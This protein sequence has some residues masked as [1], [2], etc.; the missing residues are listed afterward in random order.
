MKNII[1]I[2]GGGFARE[3]H[4]LIREI[5]LYNI[6]GFVHEKEREDMKIGKIIYPVYNEK[7]LDLHG[8]ICMAIGTGKPKLNEEIISKF[9]NKFEFPNLVHPNVTADWENITMGEGNILASNAILTTNIKIGSFN[10]F[11]LGC[12]VGHDA[13]IGNYNIINPS[14]NISGGVKICNKTFIGVNATILQNVKVNDNSIV[15]A[16]SLV[17]KDVQEFSTFVGVPAKRIK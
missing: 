7:E 12:T 11:N 6:L 8:N 14:V 1:I 16:S 3:V 10:V 15:G 17:N 4:F 2:G 9:K 5:G 13:E